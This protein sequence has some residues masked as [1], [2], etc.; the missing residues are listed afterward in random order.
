MYKLIYVESQLNKRTEVG[1]FKTQKECF[2]EAEKYCLETLGMSAIVPP[3]ANQEKVGDMIKA[4]FGAAS[5]WFEIEKVV[6]KKTA[7]ESEK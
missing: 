2:K 1:Q 3:S 4:T 7:K 5:R 6:S